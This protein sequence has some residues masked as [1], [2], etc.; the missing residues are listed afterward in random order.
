[1]GDAIDRIDLL[2]VAMH[3]IGHALG[4]D[5]DFSRF[6]TQLPGTTGPLRVTPPRA[7]AGIDI[8]VSQ[9]PHI[10]EN[11]LMVPSAKPGERRLISGIDALLMGQ[12]DLFNRPDLSEQSLE[13]NGRVRAFRR[14]QSLLPP[15]AAGMSRQRTPDPGDRV[16]CTRR[17]A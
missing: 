15:P 4:L 13:E 16:D 2:Q 17:V 8:F 12:F 9:G 1:M 11:A 6:K 5:Y 10:S 14:S 7:F 3:E